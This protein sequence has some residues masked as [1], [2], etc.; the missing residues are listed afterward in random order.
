VLKSFID[1]IILFSKTNYY[2]CKRYILYKYQT[3]II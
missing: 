2:T 3:H 1:K